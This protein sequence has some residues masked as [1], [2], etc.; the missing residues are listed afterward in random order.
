MLQTRLRRPGATIGSAVAVLAAGGLV[1]LSFAGC[2]VVAPAPVDTVGEVD[3]GT[4]LAIPPLAESHVDDDGTRVFS[5]DARAG[6]TDFAPGVPSVTWGFDGSY[7]GPT[8]VADRGERVRVDVTNSL[9][10]PTSVHWHGMHLPAAMDGGPHQMVEPDAAWSPEWVVD[11]PA[12]TLW[13]HPHPHGETEAQVAM[14]LAGMFLLHDDAERALGLPAEYGVDDIPVIV[15]DTGF[16]AEGVRE[17]PQRGYAGGLGD[18]LV[19][20]GTRGPYLEVGSELVRLR[21]LNASTART[22]AFAWSDE[23]PVDL[24]A[25][26][27]GLLETSV[28][29]DHVRLSPG[30]RAEVLL[31]VSPGE[32]VVLQSR[33]TAAISGLEPV[34]ASMNGGT[35]AFDVLEVR[36]SDALAPAASVPSTLASIED[37]DPADVATTRTF[38]LGDSFEINGEA[39]DL[40]RIDETVTVGTLERW[41]VENSNAVPHSFHVHDVQFRIA[42]IDGEAP[43]PELAGWKD[44]IFAEPETTYELLMRFDDYADPSTPYMYH[45]HL[46]WHEDQGMMGQF[47]V[48]EPGQR[49]TMSEGTHHDH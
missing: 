43:P 39:M 31:R 11:Q 30:E 13:Y 15:Q 5:L 3:F 48:V 28:A 14:G 16:S 1:A 4:P 35:D 32:R 22:Y 37:F 6:T 19:V 34:V 49:A 12:A 18:E 26:D 42:S 33:M 9:D 8:I 44:T 46:L 27:G 23:R 20:N 24:I 7:L 40:A 25:T 47:A 21:L 38:D 45:C 36:A 17:D 41:V 29:L 2:G 10:E